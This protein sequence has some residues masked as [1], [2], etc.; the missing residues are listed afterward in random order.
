MVQVFQRHLKIV[1]VV[2]KFREL[3]FEPIRPYSCRFRISRKVIEDHP[4]ASVENVE[5]SEEYP[6]HP[7]M[8]VS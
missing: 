8:N 6:D 1:G 2:L 5:T 4:V 7:L 3:F